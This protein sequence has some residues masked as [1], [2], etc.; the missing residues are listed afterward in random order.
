M[1]NNTKQQG[2]RFLIG[3]AINTLLAYA[4]YLLLLYITPYATAYT[5]S[6]VIGIISGF[7]INTYFVFH[8]KWNWRKFFSFPL[9]HIFNYIA[10]MGI[11][12]AS[13]EILGIPKQISPIIATATMLPIN[14]ILT[15]ALISDKK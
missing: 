12:V 1:P 8:S 6:Y 14:F 5:L 3:G 9:I 10:S 15:K 4:I 7:A 13:T 2:I 11:V